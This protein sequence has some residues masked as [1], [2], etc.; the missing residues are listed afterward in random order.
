MTARDDELLAAVLRR[1]L[2]ESN[3]VLDRDHHA[4]LIDDQI[5]GLS[6]EEMDAVGRAEEGEP[7]T[8]RCDYQWFED[9]NGVIVGF[10][11]TSLPGHRGPHDEWGHGEPKDARA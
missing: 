8:P 6:E 4:L 3:V 5:G 10:G 7:Q 11:C 9:H 1:F 2:T